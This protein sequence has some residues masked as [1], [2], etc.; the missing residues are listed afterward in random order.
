MKLFLALPSLASAL[1]LAAGAQAQL[2][3]AEVEAVLRRAIATAN[4]VVPGGIN[5]TISVVDQEGVVL[6]C[7]R[8][9]DPIGVRTIPFDSIV[10]GNGVGTLDG[11]FP[12]AIA[13]T[14]DA[15]GAGVP[16]A[17][18]EL[19]PANR[20]VRVA[21]SLTATTKAGTAAFLSTAGNAFTTRTAAF[22]I[23]SQFP[24][25]VTLQASGPLFG[26]QFSSLPTSDLNR[27]PL[28]L[29][30]DSGGVPLYKN[31]QCVG[32]IGVECN[33]RNA[34]TGVQSTTGTYTIDTIKAF[35]TAS[36]EERIALGGQAGFV[37]PKN[38]RADRVLV[39][40]IRFP[41]AYAGDARLTTLDANPTF[42]D[43]EVAA[44]RLSVLVT[45]SAGGAT[46]F[47]TVPLVNPVTGEVYDFYPEQAGVQNGETI[48]GYTDGVSLMTFDG[49][50]NGAENL[51][52]AEVRTALANAHRICNRLRAM[53]RRDNPLRCQVNVSVVDFAG[54]LV[55]VYRSPDAPVFGLDVSCQKA[56]SALFFSRADS[57]SIL[58][59]LEA[60]GGGGATIFATFFDA[61]GAGVGN[62]P[63]QKYRT[64]MAGLGLPLDGTIAIAERTIGAVSRERF[65]DGILRDRNGA[66]PAGPLT[67]QGPLNAA[68]APGVTNAFSVFNTGIQTDLIVSNLVSFLVTYGPGGG[69]TEAANL[70]TFAA[71]RLGNRPLNTGS[72][73]G[74]PARVTVGGGDV[75]PPNGLPDRTLANGL[76]I[77]PGGV[78]LYKNGVLVGGIGISGDGI[79]QDDTIAFSGSG[80]FDRRDQP[81]QDFQQ[82]GRAAFP[83]SATRADDIIVNR[84][85]FLR[86]PY[87]K[88]PRS[89]FQGL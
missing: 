74:V 76:Q 78:P 30:A 53:I 61:D 29:S 10:E 69:P 5:A 67:A 8:M 11:G 4:T 9:T 14:T 87:I 37:P 26:V 46:M 65:P 55:G 38:I 36:L 41:Y 52:A 18:Y 13:L 19:I 79:E 88:I 17:D 48:P 27:L 75:A 40:G 86:L 28:G 15:L 16:P 71:N 21:T 12:N 56:R 68:T 33:D 73:P 54:N 45:P 1:V 34:R 31:G 32:G 35:G 3:Q 63:F 77:F 84:T 80:G 58:T 51:S 62:G 43:D 44:G 23:Q 60:A 82:F 7:V 64:A 70:A 49:V 22:I 85:G 6:G 50:A 47:T 59:D 42:F 25:R 89:P 39:N 83:G 57:G 72:L 81:G 24:P 66:T 2:T 20:G